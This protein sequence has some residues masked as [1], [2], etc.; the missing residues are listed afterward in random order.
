MQSTIIDVIL[1]GEGDKNL[2]TNSKTMDKLLGQ[3][4]THCDQLLITLDDKQQQMLQQLQDQLGLLLLEEVERHYK[5]G[6][7]C[8]CKIM[9]EVYGNVST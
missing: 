6:F 8:G 4:V 9:M 2:R 7:S 5:E 3:I 1:R